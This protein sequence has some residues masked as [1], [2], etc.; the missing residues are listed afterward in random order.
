MEWGNP[1]RLRP[2]G[3]AIGRRAA[4]ALLASAA[5][6]TVS[7]PAAAQAN[8]AS[9]V[10]KGVIV[11]P[12]VFIRVQDLQFGRIVPGTTAGVVVVTPDGNRT[13]TGGITLVG[14]DHQPARFAGDG[15][16]NQQVRIRMGSNSIQ[17]TGPGAPMT[18]SQFTIGSTPTN[19]VLSTGWNTFTLGGTA[20]I[21]N[22]PLGAQL[23]VNANQ[24]AGTYSGTFSIELQYQ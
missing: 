3:R 1:N 2:D 18:V 23:A 21:F 15:A 22:F 19:T 20:G 6:L 10:A 7:V 11:R 17:I 14:S 4:Y 9:A 16:P 12:L 8:T 5:A 13:R 24:A